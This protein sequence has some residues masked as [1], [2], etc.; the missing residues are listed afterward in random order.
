MASN[1]LM[2]FHRSRGDFVRGTHLLRRGSDRPPRVVAGPSTLPAADGLRAA[3]NPTDSRPHAGD[4]GIDADSGPS[5]S[6]RYD[7]TGFE[8]C[9]GQHH[10]RVDAS[11]NSASAYVGARLSGGPLA[12]RLPCKR[13]T[14]PWW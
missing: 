7:L 11:Q 5:L 8:W 12:G 13:S 1:T 3:A 10:P 2:C 14:L 4:V 6:D 9:A